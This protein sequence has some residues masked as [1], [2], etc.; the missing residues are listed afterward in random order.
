[1]NLLS[2]INPS[3][4]NINCSTILSNHDVIRLKRFVSQ[5]DLNRITV[6]R[7]KMFS[8]VATYKHIFLVRNYKLKISFE[9]R[10]NFNQL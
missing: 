2:L 6:I 1:M 9:D 10:A 7:L 5:L 8:P 3:L 4:A